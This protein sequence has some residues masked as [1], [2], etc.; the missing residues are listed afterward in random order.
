MAQLGRPPAQPKVIPAQ[1]VIR[2][3]SECTYSE[4]VVYCD[5]CDEW[6]INDIAGLINPLCP[7]PGCG[8][9]METKSRLVR[10]A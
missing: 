2:R 7:N 5:G 1:S 10:K 3:L 4:K 6:F 9:V 8:M